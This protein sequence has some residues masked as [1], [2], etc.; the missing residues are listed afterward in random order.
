MTNANTYLGQKK[1]SPAS[2]VGHHGSIHRTAVGMV[3]DLLRL[4]NQIPQFTVS[5]RRMSR[6]HVLAAF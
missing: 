6:P 3:G 1:A 4:L 2:L 5:P